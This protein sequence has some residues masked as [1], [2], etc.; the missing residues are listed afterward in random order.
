MRTGIL[1]LIGLLACNSKPDVVEPSNDVRLNTAPH[2][3]DGLSWE[4]SPIE[5]DAR[6]RFLSSRETDE[7]FDVTG[8]WEITLRN[9]SG[10]VWEANVPRLTFEDGQGFQVAEYY[11]GEVVILQGHQSRYRQ[12]NFDIQI[13][14][15][16]LANSISTMNLWAS[17]EISD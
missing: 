6:W 16:E 12:G 2:E 11:I 10:D 7:G 4:G 1:C 9:T 3:E 14:S 13:A 8:A 15:L 5:A 17:F